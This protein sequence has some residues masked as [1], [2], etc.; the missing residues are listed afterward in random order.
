MLPRNVPNPTLVKPSSP[1]PRNARLADALGIKANERGQEV[2]EDELKSF[3]SGNHG[4]VKMV[5]GTFEDF[6]KG[7]K[8]S[9]ILPHMPLA[10]R[11]F[12]MSLAEHYRLTR[13]LIDQEPNRS[14]QIRRRVDTRVPTP[15]LSAVAQ[16]TIVQPLPGPSRL[17]TSLNGGS[18][19][20]WGRSAGGKGLTAAGIVASSNTSTASSP[21]LGGWGSN[22][23]SARPSRVP[24]PVAPILSERSAP[25][26][27]KKVVR[28]SGGKSAQGGQGDDD[29]DV[30]V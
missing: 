15:L 29:W 22:A 27:P 7:A 23:G 25:P 14:V 10:K 8:Q 2:Y 9:M 28:G 19:G 1:S 6:L 5:E 11:T 12:V 24:T 4:F 18:S 26:S 3:A 16:P 30:D 13:E 21:T 20:G 17:V